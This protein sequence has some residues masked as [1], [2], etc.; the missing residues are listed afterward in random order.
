MFYTRIPCPK[1]IGY[2]DDQMN[3]STRYFPA[4]G[5]IVGL[6]VAAVM[7]A[8]DLVLPTTVAVLLG[9]AVGVAVTGFFHEDG[10]ADVCDGF[11]GGATRERTLEIMKD[12]RLGAFA[13]IGL[14][15]LFGIKIT[16]W[17]ALIDLSGWRAYLG[18]VFAHVFSRWCAVTIIFTSVYARADLTSKVKPIG[19]KI[20]PGGFIAATAWLLPFV[21]LVWLEPGWLI[22]MPVGFLVRIALSHWFTVRLGGYTGDCLG[23]AQQSIETVMGLVMLGLAGLG[24]SM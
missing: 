6:I 10:F 2:S 19:R 15:L 5:W 18:L 16:A 3:R 1:W 24:W 9:L 7:W 8:A 4:I 22:A 12:S 14:I 21:G 23:S 11:G 17:S 13:T 20:S